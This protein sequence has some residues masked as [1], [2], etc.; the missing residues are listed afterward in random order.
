MDVGKKTGRGG[1]GEQEINGYQEVSWRKERSGLREHGSDNGLGR[2]K[3]KKDRKFTFVTGEKEEASKGDVM[4]KDTVKLTAR[5]D[6]RWKKAIFSLPKYAD[7]LDCNVS[8]TESNFRKLVPSEKKIK[9]VIF[10][11]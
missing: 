10:F 3:K 1:F 5:E 8:P 6:A 7:G 4:G 11:F 9:Y 2:V